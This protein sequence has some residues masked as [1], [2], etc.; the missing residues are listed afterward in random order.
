V[1]ACV[2]GVIIRLGELNAVLIRILSLK[3]IDGLQS[4]YMS[5]KHGQNVV[6]MEKHA[7]H[8]LVVRQRRRKVLASSKKVSKVA[9]MHCDFHVVC[10]E[11]CFVDCHCSLEILESQIPFLLLLVQHRQV[12]AYG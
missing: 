10:R 7:S 8:P 12:G 9:A 3:D 11:M 4:T 5:N 2:P 1:H 6:R